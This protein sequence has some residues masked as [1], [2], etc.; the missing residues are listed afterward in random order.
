[1]KA[2]S[3]EELRAH[4]GKQNLFLAVKNSLLYSYCCKVKVM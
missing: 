2:G 4:I 3:V 1:M